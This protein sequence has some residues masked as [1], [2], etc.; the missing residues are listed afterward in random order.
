MSVL[1]LQ[2][3]I[4][5]HHLQ[6]EDM[7]VEEPL[8]EC[9]GKDNETCKKKFYKI[10][11]IASHFSGRYSKCKD[12]YSEVERDEFRKAARKCT[13]EKYHNTNRVSIN[14]KQKIRDQENRETKNEKQRIYNMDNRES[15]N[16]KQRI[17]N[18]DNRESINEKQNIRDVDNRE[19]KN[20]KQKIRNIEN[21]ATKKLH[22][23]GCAIQ[24]FSVLKICFLYIDILKLPRWHSNVTEI[25]LEF[26][27]HSISKQP[28]NL[29]LDFNFQICQIL[30]KWINILLWLFDDLKNI[31]L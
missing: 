2:I 17:Y 7:S 13:V 25:L 31:R 20:E 14:E 29:K 28:K 6:L 1:S 9:R 8:I 22:N 26:R 12:L 21:R 5:F 15:I 4:I 16:E 23:T 27:I 24:N 19:S 30:T 3:C 18:V 11:E 10:E